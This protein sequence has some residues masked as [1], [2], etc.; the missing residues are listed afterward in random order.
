MSMSQLL[1]RG[2]ARHIL[3]MMAYCLKQ[4]VL[5]AAG[6]EDDY[7][8]KEFY[9]KHWDKW[10]FGYLG[11]PDDYDWKMFRFSLYMMCRRS[12]LSMFAD[13]YL[14]E[15]RRPDYLFC[16]LIFAMRF[17]LM[18]VKEWIDYPNRSKIDIYRMEVSPM[19][20]TPGTIFSRKMRRTNVLAII[21]DIAY[22]YRRWAGDRADVKPS[23]NVVVEFSS[24]LFTLTAKM[25]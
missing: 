2:S 17:Y 21:Q 8:V 4:G 10:D 11:E 3:R 12:H 25:P 13:S 6:M 23:G 16:P 1:N 9:A 24:A 5:D 18:G 19:H 15:I 20:F 22:R 14:Y 7:A